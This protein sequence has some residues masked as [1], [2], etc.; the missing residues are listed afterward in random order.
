MFCTRHVVVF[1]LFANINN[2]QQF[3]Q[4]MFYLCEN[5]IQFGYTYSADTPKP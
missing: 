2:I 5:K 1:L 3:P 4:S